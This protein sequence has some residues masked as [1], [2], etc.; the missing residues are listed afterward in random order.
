MV[1][2][3][4]ALVSHLSIHSA[5]PGSTG[6]NELAGGGYARQAVTWTAAA[7]GLVHSVAQ[8]SFS[9][10]AGSTAAYVGF[11][12]ALTAG[13]F[14]GSAPVGSGSYGVAYGDAATDVLS[15]PAHGLA[16]GDE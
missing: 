7:T 14:Y 5:S 11:W 12:S 3:L 15:A 9:V 2:A 1:T 10:P 6:I 16:L 8:V 4:A 13:T